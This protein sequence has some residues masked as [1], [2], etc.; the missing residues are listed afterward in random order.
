[1]NLILGGIVLIVLGFVIYW[2][3][4]RMK[5]RLSGGDDPTFGSVAAAVLREILIAIQRV[6]GGPTTGD[7]FEGLGSLTTYLGLL[8]IIIGA[9]QQLNPP[10]AG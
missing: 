6:F 1:V 10:A 2:F 3:G 5:A 9:F 7:R 8:L 4:A